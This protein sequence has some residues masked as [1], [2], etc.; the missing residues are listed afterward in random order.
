MRAI[1]RSLSG[2]A[3]SLAE[4]LIGILLLV[5]PVGFSAAVIIIFGVVLMLLGLGSTI[6]YFRTD[7]EEAAAS[8]LLAKGLAVF[9]AGSLCAFQTHWFLEVFPALTVLYGV[10]ILLTGLT[11][12]QWTVDII[13]MKRSGWIWAAVGAFVTVL[14]GG[15][16]LANP[17]QTVVALW[18]FI[19]VS[20]IV[21]AVIDIV[22]AF[23]GNREPRSGD[24]EAA[25]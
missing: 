7:P 11:K 5:N 21:E 25:E 14:C 8:Q 9:L 10:V 22:S 20:L 24:K 1:K 18:V 17:F 3:M 13:R 2:I 12:L 15:V 4:L 6:R 16:I 23:Y 19:G